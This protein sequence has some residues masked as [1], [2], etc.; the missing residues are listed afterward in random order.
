MDPR[1]F[2]RWTTSVAAQRSRRVTL[3]VLAGGLLGGLLAQRAITATRAAQR[4]D[5]D[6]D[7]L[8]DDDE[9]QVYGTNPDVYNTDGDGVG[10]GEEVYYGSDPLAAD[11]YAGL[12]GNGNDVSLGANPD[13]G[14]IDI[15]DTGPIGPPCR[16]IGVPCDTDDQCCSIGAVL[17]CWDGVS[18][19]TE[20]ADVT[21]Y[22]GV[23]P[24]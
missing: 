24:I 23:C 16:G 19:R 11:S 1:T 10:D 17:C 2:D 20:C 21:A 3:R 15:A 13:D 14:A 12:V 18:L 6:G 8:F 22:G 7:G 4:T 9:V 5:T